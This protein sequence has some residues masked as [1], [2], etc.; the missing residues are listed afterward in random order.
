[1]EHPEGGDDTRSWGP[2]FTQNRDGTHGESAYFRSANRG[3]KSVSVDL[4]SGAGRDLARQYARQSD[5]LVE[6]FRVGG[7]AQLGLDYDTLSQ[8]NPTLIYCSIT[9][10]G[11][12]G[13][14]RHRPGYDLL[15]QAMGGLM[16]ITGEPEGRPMKAGV[17]LTDIMTGL[18]ATSAILAALHERGQSGKGDYIDLSLLDVQIATLA[19]QA[20]NYLVSGQSP[21]RSGNVHPNIA[22]YQDFATSDGA[23]VIAVG[24]DSQFLRLCESLEAHDLAKDPRFVSNALRV[25]NR[26][27]LAQVITD[28]LTKGSTRHW[29]VMLDA[30]GIPAAAIND[31]AAVFSEPQVIAREMLQHSVDGA[32]LVACPIRYRRLALATARSAPYLGEHNT[33]S[34]T[35]D[36]E[37]DHLGS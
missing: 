33:Y 35:A 4:K 30:N 25:E 29:L 7:A 20:Q 28:L 36:L 22:P 9:G 12:T 2:P 21:Q 24:N 37:P 34:W 18:Y 8:E 13:P 23:I 15:V 11:Q 31:L 17:A 1:M 19:N 27:A 26:T 16:S 10:F 14:H 6:N 3:K 32:P 5:I